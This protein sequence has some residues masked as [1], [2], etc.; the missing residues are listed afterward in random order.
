MK[1]GSG[2]FST[3]RKLVPVQSIFSHIPMFHSGASGLAWQRLGIEAGS[4]LR[5]HGLRYPTSSLIPVFFR[6]YVNPHHTV[7]YFKT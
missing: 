7:G 1:G 3:S 2:I 6:R 5:T 4:L